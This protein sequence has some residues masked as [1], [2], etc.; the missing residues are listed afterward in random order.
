[1]EREKNL[2]PA[3]QVLASFSNTKIEDNFFSIF[4]VGVVKVCFSKAFYFDS[5]GT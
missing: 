2:N 3:Y 4:Y 5:S 1:M